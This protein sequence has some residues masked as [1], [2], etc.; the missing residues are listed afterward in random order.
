MKETLG[1]RAMRAEKQVNFTRQDTG[2][3]IAANKRGVKLP[4]LITLSDAAE[5]WNLRTSAVCSART[6]T[7]HAAIEV[8][9]AVEQGHISLYTAIKIAETIPKEKHP[10]VIGK[11]LS[12]A[13][14][15]RGQTPISK[16]LGVTKS[17]KRSPKRS[18]EWRAVRAL[19]QLE[20]SVDALETLFAERTEKRWHSMASSQ[21]KRLILLLRIFLEKEGKGN[22]NSKV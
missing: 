21:C 18:L 11:I 10:D 14:N 13:K 4:E 16:I 20:N 2:R 1:Q 12:T 22:D 8:V 17:F 5:A 9:R 19:D 3:L 6:I 7:R 15:G